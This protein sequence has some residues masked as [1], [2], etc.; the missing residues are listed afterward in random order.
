M[1][2][3]LQ[4]SRSVLYL[5]LNFRGVKMAKKRDPINDFVT[6]VLKIRIIYI[7]K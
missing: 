7:Q 2:R 4:R 3:R 1:A 5:N 6:G